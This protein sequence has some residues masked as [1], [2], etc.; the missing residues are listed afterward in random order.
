MPSVRMLVEQRTRVA[1]LDVHD[2]AVG[3]RLGE[4]VEQHARVVDHQVAVEEQV[5]VR[6]QATRPPAARS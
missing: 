6:A 4:V 2:A 3:A 5:G 1:E